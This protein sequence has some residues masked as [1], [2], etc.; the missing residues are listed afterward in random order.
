MNLGGENEGPY[1]VYN[2]QIHH[3][4]NLN[5]LN[6]SWLSQW[7]HNPVISIIRLNQRNFKHKNRI[8]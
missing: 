1:Q 6:P 4:S 2:F 8:L 3:Y 7:G 5:L